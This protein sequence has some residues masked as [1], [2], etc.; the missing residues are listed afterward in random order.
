MM[1]CTLL[2]LLKAI[3]AEAMLL[4]EQLLDRAF[5]FEDRS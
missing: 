5:G 2:Q 4:I 3:K 1:H